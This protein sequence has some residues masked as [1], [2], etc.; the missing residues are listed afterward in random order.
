MIDRRAFTFRLG[1]AGLGAAALLPLVGPG[2]LA[3]VKERPRGLR[4]YNTNT[5]EKF[6]ELYYDGGYLKAALEKL[7]WFM[8]DHHEGVQTHMDR[9]LFDLLWRL[10]ERYRRAQHGHVVIN[11][12]S[13]YRTKKTNDRLRAEGAARNSQHLLGKAADVTIQGYGIYFLVN[14]ASRIGAGGLGLY[15]AA[16]FVHLDT[17]P[18]R[19]WYKL[20]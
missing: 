12:N 6:D 13:A 20:Y 11:I 14:H 7:D 2:A 9:A 8:R 3:A 16:K 10:A 5:K 15:W 4:L 17:G 19:Y 18:K 1:A